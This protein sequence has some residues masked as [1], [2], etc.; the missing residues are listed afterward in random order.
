M[1][2]PGAPS[3]VGRNLE[4]GTETAEVGREGGRDGR[5]RGGE[6]KGGREGK[7]SWTDAARA[8]NE[9]Q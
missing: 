4:T 8:T 9:S 2:V 7:G 3:D 6:W 5:G 1:H